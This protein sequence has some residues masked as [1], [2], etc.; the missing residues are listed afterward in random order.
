MAGVVAVYAS[1]SAP[2][3][4]SS[5]DTFVSVAAG[6]ATVVSVLFLYFQ[7]RSDRVRRAE[8]RQKDR[9]EQKSRDEQLRRDFYGDSRPGIPPRLSVPMML[10]NLSDQVAIIHAEITPNHGGSIKD[11]IGRIDLRLEAVE[12]D[13]K[14]LHK[15][16]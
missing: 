2:A 5:L 10:E 13:V 12:T 1:A 9:D 7:A 4:S 16:A 3:G 6:I 14:S 15:G 11:A 8:Q